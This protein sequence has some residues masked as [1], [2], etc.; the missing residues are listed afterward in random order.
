M[1]RLV[2][3][4][5]NIFT[6]ISVG[7]RP[8]NIIMNDA[9]TSISPP[10]RLA[11]VYL[12]D[13]TRSLLTLFLTLDSRLEDIAVKMNEVMI[14]Q[15]RIAW[16]RDTLRSNNKPKGEPFIAMID[17]VQKLFPNYD[18]IEPL[19]AMVDGWEQL[20]ISDNYMGIETMREYAQQRGGAPFKF[21]A[22]I[23][24]EDELAEEYEKLG[25]I[26][27]LSPIF[28]QEGEQGET[29]RTMALAYI[30][31]LNMKQLSQKIRALSILTFPAV[32]YLNNMQ[33]HEHFDERKFKYALAYIWHAIS[34][35]W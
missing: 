19:I 15:I 25:Q 26:W 22:H 35:R 27:A 32:R 16:W 28:A 17:D 18:I 30:D 34:G 21:F 5:N 12:K 1:D 9:N 10:Q 8:V 4:V 3:R 23:C 14:A 7:N 11:L 33:N 2:I 20:I 6:L 13:E 24:G 29:A 31:Q